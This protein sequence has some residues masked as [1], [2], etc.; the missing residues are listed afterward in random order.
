MLSFELWCQRVLDATPRQ[1]PAPV[2]PAK[3][4]APAVVRL[5]TAQTA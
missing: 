3:R 1:Q 2:R 4:I 5:T